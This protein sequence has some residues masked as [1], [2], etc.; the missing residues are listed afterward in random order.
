MRARVP[1]SSK[2]FCTFAPVRADASM[3]RALMLWAKFSPSCDRAPCM[4]RH[5]AA[6]AVMAGRH[7]RGIG[8]LPFDA[9]GGRT[10]L[11]TLR[12]SSTSALLPTITTTTLS[13]AAFI[14]LSSLYHDRTS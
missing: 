1:A 13:L 8:R 3:K 5:P 10:S 6:A 7:G 12:L 9:R 2:I 4:A 14:W 11:E